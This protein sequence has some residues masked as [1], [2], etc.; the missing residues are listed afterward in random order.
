MLQKNKVTV[1]FAVAGDAKV[2]LYKKLAE[3]LEGAYVSK[4]DSKQ[5]TIADIV[6][7][8]YKVRK[9]FHCL[10]VGLKMILI[11]NV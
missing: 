3:S 10:R 9:Y 7:T 8:S 5:Y 2:T 11:T 1:V 4:L 6:K